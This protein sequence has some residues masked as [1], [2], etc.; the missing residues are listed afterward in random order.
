MDISRNIPKT[1]VDTSIDSDLWR[2]AKLNEI[3]WRDALEFGIKFR[4]AEMNGSEYPSND[5]LI[6]IERL[7]GLIKELTD[8]KDEQ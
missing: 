2:I 4:L 1:R 8:K 3:N 5:L 6:K 7:T